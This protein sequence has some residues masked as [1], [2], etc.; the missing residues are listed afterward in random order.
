[1]KHLQTG[2]D[3]AQ[4][5]SVIIQKILKD[6]DLADDLLDVMIDFEKHLQNLLK[7]M[8][9]LSLGKGYTDRERNV[10]KKCFALSL[11]TANTNKSVELLANNLLN[12]LTNISEEFADL[13]NVENT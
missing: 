13:S 3:I 1:M 6:Q 10:Y 8:V 9:K 7:T 12:L 2:L 5:S 4:Q 11:R